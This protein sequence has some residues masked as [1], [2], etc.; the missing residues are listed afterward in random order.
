MSKIKDLPEYERPREKALRHGI[1]ALSDAE[2]IS[3]LLSSGY[4][5]SNVNC[6]ST[7]LLNTYNSLK[8]LSL[9]PLDDYFKFKGIKTSKALMLAATFEIHR[10]IVR[11]ESESN[12]SVIDSEYLFNKYKDELL[13]MYQ[14]VVIIVIVNSK[15]QISYENTLYKGNS[16]Q[17]LISFKDIWRELLTHKG[18]GFY[19]IHNHPS[20][21]VNPSEQDLF[22][23]QELLRESKTLKIQLL[24][25]III[26]EN[27]YTSIIKMI[28]T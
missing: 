8:N 15:N 20:G 25:H 13:V 26:G 5:G 3:L 4:K 23:T 7:S 14:E 1:G 28:K 18:K 11:Q 24:D 22:I 19:L 6:I 17:V 21:D 9:S 2:L 10:R 27:G 16:A 12:N